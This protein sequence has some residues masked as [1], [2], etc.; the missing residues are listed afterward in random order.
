MKAGTTAP[1]TE[2]YVRVGSARTDSAAAW[3]TWVGPMRMESSD[4][5]LT[6]MATDEITTP[7]I[8][9]HTG[10]ACDGMDSEHDA[11]LE[12]LEAVS[13]WQR[14]EVIEVAGIRCHNKRLAML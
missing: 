6:G 2:N 9:R 11:K 12:E 8:G 7:H 3:T 13:S 1:P 14:A 4:P 5:Q 10:R